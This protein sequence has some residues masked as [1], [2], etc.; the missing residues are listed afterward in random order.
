MAVITSLRLLGPGGAV[1]SAVEA[2]PRLNE[3]VT[4]LP[5]QTEVQGLAEIRH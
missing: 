1:M 5:W 2:A 3:L 4:P